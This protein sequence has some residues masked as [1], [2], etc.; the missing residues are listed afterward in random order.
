MR[1]LLKVG[2]HHRM[3]VR[4]FSAEH[5]REVLEVREALERIAVMHACASMPVEAMDEL[6]T[7]LRRRK[8]AVEAEDEAAFI[9]LD[10]LFHLRIAAGTGLRVVPRILTQLR[11]FVRVMRVGTVRARGHLATV[12]AEHRRLLAAIEARDVPYALRALEDHLHTA[13]YPLA[14]DGGGAASLPSQAHGGGSG[15]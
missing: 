6:H 12:L 7:L 15:A 8:R 9:E 1:R 3:V 11:G 4:G 10:E 14:A 13:N 2:P 5:R